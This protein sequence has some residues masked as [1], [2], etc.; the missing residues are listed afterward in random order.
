M[1]IR[2]SVLL[3]A[4]AAVCLTVP[5]LVGIGTGHVRPATL[6]ALGALWG[7]SQ[8]GLDAWPVRSR[9]LLWLA[10]A[11]LVGFGI[12]SVVGLWVTASVARIALLGLAGLTSGYLQASGLVSFGAY[13]LLGVIVGRGIVTPG[14]A[15]WIPIV[16]S[17]GALWVW[18]V[19]A[20]MDRRSRH[21]VLRQCIADA[22]VALDHAIASIGRAV[23]G[24]TAN[25]ACRGSS[26]G[27][28]VGEAG[29]PNRS[30]EIPTD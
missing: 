26:V 22:L 24:T 12:G 11:V 16:T 2:S 1:R 19:A 30:H 9:R 29:R 25:A 17:L 13:G 23:V 20:A 18:G 28:D 5:L 14:S 8:D 7:V 15:W 3:S 27:F 10:L 4:R 6:F 21:E